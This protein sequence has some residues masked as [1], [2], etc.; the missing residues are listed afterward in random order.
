MSAGRPALGCGRA[1]RKMRRPA[2]AWG[3][4]IVIFLPRLHLPPPARRAARYW[5]TRGFIPSRPNPDW[6]TN[7]RRRLRAGA[8]RRAGGLPVELRRHVD[9][10]IVRALAA[11]QAGCGY[12]ITLI[13]PM[14][15]VQRPAG[16]M[17]RSLRC[18]PTV[19]R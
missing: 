3:R 9:H 2:P 7:W 5:R 15:P 19:N 10:R 18:R 1:A 11:E 16:Q 14:R 17:R 12:G 8:G 13:I 6:W 4:F